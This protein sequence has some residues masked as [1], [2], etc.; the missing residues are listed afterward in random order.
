MRKMGGLKKHMPTTYWTFL[1]ATLA[2]AGI[3]VF[4]GFFS[5]DE[6]L[7]KVFSAGHGGMGETYLVL[8]AMGLAGAFLT[9]FYMFRLVYS[10]F[11]G[12]FR[13][14]HEQEHHLHESPGSMTWPLRILAVGSATIG[15][16][17]IGKALTFETA[18]INLFEHFLHPVAPDFMAHHVGLGIEWTLIVISVVVAASGILLAR[19]MYFGPRAFEAPQRIAERFPVA[20]DVVANKFYVD[21]AYDATVIAGTMKLARGSWEFDA[22]VIDGAVNGT[23]HVTVGTSFFSGLFDL[24]VVDGAVNLTAWVYKVWS[25]GHKRLQRGVVQ[26]YALVMA[27]GFLLMVAAALL[28][29]RAF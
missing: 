1:V 27:L 25:L 8:W 6:I 4:A 11:H 5:K 29:G 15:F 12:E 16:I 13:G 2:L 21:E 22:R 17:G 10:T 7:G 9:A 14:T 20:Y 18:D 24:N 28:L 23:R 3:P 26:S 19:R